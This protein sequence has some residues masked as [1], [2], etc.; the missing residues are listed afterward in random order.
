VT[1]SQDRLAIG[2]SCP[3]TSLVPSNMV[4]ALAKLQIGASRSGAILFRRFL[5]NITNS[6][7]GAAL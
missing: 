7:R 1:G 3:I 2:A 4:V 6:G 5:S